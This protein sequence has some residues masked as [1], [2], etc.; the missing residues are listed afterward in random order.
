MTA[1]MDNHPFIMYSP[2]LGLWMAWRYGYYATGDDHHEA[3]MMWEIIYN[4]ME[5]R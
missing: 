5:E 4:T 2:F 3:A 1:L